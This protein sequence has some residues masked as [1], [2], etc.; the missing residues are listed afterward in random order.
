M[1]LASTAEVRLHAGQTESAIELAD[2]AA[3]M[4]E[5]REQ[6]RGLALLIRAE[7]MA[8]SGKSPALVKAAFAK[9]V[10]TLR[11][12]PTRMRA[13]AHR[14]LGQYLARRGRTTDA[15]AELERAVTL[16]EQPPPPRR[17]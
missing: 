15:L 16:L 17:A 13:R 9:A 1:I 5:A 2:A 14:S 11:H 6:T 3:G 7:A 4:S 12:E 8:A 10:K